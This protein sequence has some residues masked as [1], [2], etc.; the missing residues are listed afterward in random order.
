MLQTA[1]TMVFQCTWPGCFEIRTT[2]TLIEQ[3]V[4]EGHLG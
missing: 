3:H 2:C 1:K 4:R